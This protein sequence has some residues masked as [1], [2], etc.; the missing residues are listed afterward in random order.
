[1]SVPSARPQNHRDGPQ[2]HRPGLLGVPYVLRAALQGGEERR[3]A[4]S[5][6]FLILRGGNAHLCQ[7]QLLSLL[8]CPLLFRRPTLTFAIPTP[9]HPHPAGCAVGHGT[10]FEDIVQEEMDIHSPRLLSDQS[11]KYKCLFESTKW[12][13][14]PSFDGRDRFQGRLVR[15]GEY[16]QYAEAWMRLLPPDRLLFVKNE[17]MDGRPDEVMREVYKFAGLRP[18]PTPVLHSNFAACRGSIAR[19]A[20][21]PSMHDKA[22]SGECA[23][24]GAGKFSHQKTMSADMARRLMEHFR[25]RNKKFTEMTGIPTDDWATPTKYL[26]KGPGEEGGGGGGTPALKRERRRRAV[27]AHEV[28]GQEGHVGRGGADGAAAPTLETRQRWRR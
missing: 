18:V 13:T 22:N 4:H 26:E 7:L 16:A 14:V 15:W 10:T 12:Q 8:L 21:T 23:R 1:M 2:P 6:I 25:E 24:M 3:A 19:G 9:P 5:L 17:D 28:G 20:W 27:L 11:L